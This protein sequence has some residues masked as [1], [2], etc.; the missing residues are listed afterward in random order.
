MACLFF[1]KNLSLWID[2]KRIVA[3]EPM[4]RDKNSLND[5][6][7]MDLKRTFFWKNLISSKFLKKA[8]NSLKYN[9]S[10]MHIH[11]RLIVGDSTLK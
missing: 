3:H 8:I 11:S 4:A 1:Q 9:I 6:R 10:S 5:D 2:A 7:N